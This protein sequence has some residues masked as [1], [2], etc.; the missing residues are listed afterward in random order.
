[1]ASAGAAPWASVSLTAVSA[2][3]AVTIF[4]SSMATMLSAIWGASAAA[5]ADLLCMPRLRL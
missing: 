4:A 2:V 1:M 5:E 3:V